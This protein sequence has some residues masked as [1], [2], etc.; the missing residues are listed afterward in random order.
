MISLTAVSLVYF[1]AV[2]AGLLAIEHCHNGGKSGQVRA[3]VLISTQ[4]EASRLGFPEHLET[5]A[6]GW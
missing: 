6:N 1:S 5:T 2:C 4:D 3:S